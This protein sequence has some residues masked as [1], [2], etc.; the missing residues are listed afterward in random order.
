M[1]RKDLVVEHIGGTASKTAKI[2]K[3]A[4]GV[5]LFVEEAYTLCS[6]FECDFGKKALEMLMASMNN[7]GNPNIKNPIM[8]FARYKEQMNDFLKMNSGLTRRVKIVLN[9]SDYTPEDLCD[10]TE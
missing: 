2:I 6:F 3:K 5:V 1:Q 7:N 8:I 4:K 10:I 9:F